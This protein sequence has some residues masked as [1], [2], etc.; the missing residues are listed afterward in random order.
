MTDCVR[1][2]A[3]T[4]R[5]TL[6][7]AVPEAFPPPLSSSSIRYSEKLWSHVQTQWVHEGLRCLS[8]ALSFPDSTIPWWRLAFC[9]CHCP[10]TLKVL[11]GLS[12]AVRKAG[13]AWF[14]YRRRTNFDPNVE[15][16][17]CWMK[18]ISVS[19]C[20]T[21]ITR[22]DLPAHP[23]LDIPEAR[24]FGALLNT[25]IQVYLNNTDEAWV[26]WFGLGLEK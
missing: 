21:V 20:S 2:S 7:T 17:E 8:Q 16:V 6:S 12:G 25:E 9:L 15:Y 23:N 19:L 18:V 24:A 22:R 26:T 4:Y 13:V 5:Q 3:L 10:R 11:R 14:C 1:E